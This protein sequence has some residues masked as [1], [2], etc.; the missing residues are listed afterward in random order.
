[1]G[2]FTAWRFLTILPLPLGRG[3]SAE[4][5]GR[6][7]VYFP[8]VGLVLGL[9]LAGLDRGLDSVL[10][11]SV[12]SGLLLVILVL[13][14]G[15]THLDGFI[16]T[17]D[18]LVAGRSPEQRREIM[19]DSRVGAFG[20]V[21]ACCLIVLKYASLAALSDGSRTWTLAVMPVLGRWMVVCA[22]AAFPYARPEGLGR[23][24]KNQATWLTVAAATVVGLA[25]SVGFLRLTGL[26]IMFGVAL[27][28]LSVCAILNRK[29]AG[30]TGDTYGAVIEVA[31]VTTLVLA[32]AL[33]RWSW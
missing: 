8:V 7:L 1:V 17:C 25:A 19:R 29:F 27:V 32:S 4:Q 15:A 20:V 9:A 23:T 3:A 13:V 26:A 21:G 2:F 6:S 18:G 22:I 14:S 30:L 33:P 31:E 28:A 12:L 5:V 24:F 11:V 10:P 16:D